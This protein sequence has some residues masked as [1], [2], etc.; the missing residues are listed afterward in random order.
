MQIIS[1][2]QFQWLNIKFSTPLN[3]WPSLQVPVTSRSL[4]NLW[5]CFL[6]ANSLKLCLSECGKKTKCFTT[7]LWPSP[8]SVSSSS[9]YPF[10]VLLRAQWKRNLECC[11]SRKVLRVL[12]S[13]VLESKIKLTRLTN[14]WLEVL[15]CCSV[16]L[17]VFFKFS[18]KH[19]W[20]LFFFS[21]R[22]QQCFQSHCCHLPHAITPGSGPGHSLPLVQS[23]PVAGSPATVETFG[24]EQRFNF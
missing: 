6:L 12:L 24:K 14:T 7:W 3:D 13:G 9:T 10:G 17:V 21:C 18:K 2:P 15:Q 20:I 22:K 5:V 23:G 11:G 8:K 19:L 16:L 1:D 4:R